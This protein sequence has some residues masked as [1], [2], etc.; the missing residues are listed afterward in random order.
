[1]GLIEIKERRKTMAWTT[2][3][4]DSPAILWLPL[5]HPEDENSIEHKMEMC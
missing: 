4:V 1:L 2:M 5:A 3:L